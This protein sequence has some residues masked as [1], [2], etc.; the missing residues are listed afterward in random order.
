VGGGGALWL[1]WSR[2]LLGPEET[3]PFVHMV[4]VCW[5]LCEGVV[6]FGLASGWLPVWVVGWGCGWFFEFC[7]VDASIFCS[8]VVFV[9][10]VLVFSSC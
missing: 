10:C 7:I 8:C 4:I 2:T 1:L 6:F 5:L 9:C 3:G